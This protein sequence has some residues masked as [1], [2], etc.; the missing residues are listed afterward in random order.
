MF[1]EHLFIYCPFIQ[2]SF[3]YLSVPPSVCLSVH[4]SLRPSRGRSIKQSIHP[5]SDP[6]NHPL[7]CLLSLCSSVRPLNPSIQPSICLDVNPS[8]NQSVI[9]S[10]CLFIRLSIHPIH[11]VICPSLILSICLTS[12]YCFVHQFQVNPLQVL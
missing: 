2:K 10:L 11:L 12:V 9:P 6:S 7:V 5:S 8:V 3:I 1:R 4:A